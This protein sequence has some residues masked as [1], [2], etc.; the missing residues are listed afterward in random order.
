MPQPDHAA[1]PA[2]SR[3]CPPNGFTR[4]RSERRC[5]PCFY[6]A[7]GLI[8]AVQASK[9]DLAAVMKSD[10]GRALGGRGKAWVRSTLVLVQVS[11]SFV[12]LIDAG[13]LLKSG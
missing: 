4:A 11:L 8:P 10:S 13:L 1:V 3:H 6:A 12:L 2:P 7:V 9:I 5:L